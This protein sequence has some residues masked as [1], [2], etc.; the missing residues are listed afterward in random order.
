MLYEV[1]TIGFL[2]SYFYGFLIIMFPMIFDIILANRLIAKQVDRGS[3]SNILA[4]PNTRNKISLTYMTSMLIGVTV[5]ISFNTVVGIIAAEANF[6]GQLD[7]SKFIVLNIGALLLHYAISGICFFASCFFNDTKN[8]LA[9][10]AGV[11]I[12]FFLIQ[13]L[14]NMGGK[15]ENMKYLTMY[16][17]FNPDGIIAG[18][19]NA[20]ISII[21]LGVI[22]CVLYTSGIRNNF[23]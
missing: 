3:M 8:S 7:I 5:L 12:A 16:T 4:T 23:V 15:L 11:P 9:V 19:T 22:S 6:S 18:E 1:I 2:S 20:I 14:A 21:I 13:M 17:L 10:G